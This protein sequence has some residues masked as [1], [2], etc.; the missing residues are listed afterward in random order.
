[1]IPIALLFVWL[2]GWWLVAM[3][4]LGAMVLGYE[5]SSLAS[6]PNRWVVSVVACVPLILLPIFG[7]R[8]SLG[9]LLLLAVLAAFL[10]GGDSRQILRAIFGAIYA[11]G[12]ALAFLMLREG[13]WNGQAAALMLMGMVWASDTGAYFTGRHLGGPL[14][15]PKNSPNKTWSGALGGVAA[16]ALCG[17]IAAHIVSA[18]ILRWVVFAALL[19]VVCQY[20]DLIESRIKREFGAKDASSILPGH[21]GLMDRVD[22]LGAVCI[23][24]CALFMMFPSLLKYMGL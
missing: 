14:L 22:G 8:V 19:S 20:G 7:L 17:P 15:S 10:Q 12:M 24:S 9:S 3:C 2:G 6:L 1:M 5:W 11:G 13:N 21:G 18:P 23:V 4:V 16:T